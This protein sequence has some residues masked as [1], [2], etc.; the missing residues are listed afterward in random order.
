LY[1]SGYWFPGQLKVD[2]HL[3]NA[4]LSLGDDLAQA[5]HSILFPSGTVATRKCIQ[6]VVH[7]FHIGQFLKPGIGDQPGLFK[8]I[9]QGKMCGHALNYI[10]IFRYVKRINPV[11]IH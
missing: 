6:Q 7:A 3:L 1:S 10:Q 2:Q 11:T 4:A 5:Q 8:I 9:D